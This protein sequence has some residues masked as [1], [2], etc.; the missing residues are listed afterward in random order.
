MNKN[1]EKVL[2]YIKNNNI[3]LKDSNVILV[4]IQASCSMAFVDLNDSCLMMGNYWDFHNGCH[5]MDIPEFNSYS[6]LVSLFK[7]SIL[8][9]GKSVEVVY[10]KNWVYED[11]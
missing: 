8:A 3:E 9:S 1:Q 2:Q 10:D 11:D 7:D 6:E 4:G 5:G